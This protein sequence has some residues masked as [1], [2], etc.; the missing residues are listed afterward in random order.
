MSS[1]PYDVEMCRMA[2][3]VLSVDIGGYQVS[4]SG[5]VIFGEGTQFNA[6]NF[7]AGADVRQVGFVN[8]ANVSDA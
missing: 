2:D 7:V 1:E 5:K 6:L 4:L 8:S 3:G